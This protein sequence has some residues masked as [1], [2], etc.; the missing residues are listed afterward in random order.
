MTI[1]D[2]ILLGIVEGITEFLPI[3]STAHMVITSRILHIPETSFLS[4]F[5]IAIQLGA[6][7]SIIFLYA[8][9]VLTDWETF[10]R[11]VVAFVPTALIGYTLYSLLKEVLIDSLPIIA[12]AL[13]LGGIV[14]ILFEKYWGQRDLE[15][16]PS[17]SA[18]SYKTAVLIGCAQA[19]AIIPGVSRAGATIIGGMALGLRRTDIVEFS[20]LLAVPT[21]IMA[22]AYDLYKS[23]A[24]IQSSEWQLLAVGF[25]VAF[26]SAMIAVKALVRFV[27]THNFTAF[28][29]YR[30]VLGIAILLTLAFV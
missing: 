2:A 16:A 15:N 17:I 22:T 30:I 26:F 3:S 18:M 5:I 6:I 25:L 1:L 24:S 4:T 28:G 20:F 14:L 9:R 12:W 29:Y 21:M 27:S 7:A 13:I 10:K 19:L 23:G 11:I 8:R